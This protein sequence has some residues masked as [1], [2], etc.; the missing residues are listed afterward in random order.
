MTGRPDLLL[1]LD[2]EPW[3]SVNTPDEA[4]VIL[5][6]AEAIL[7][8]CEEAG[9]R[10]TL[11]VDILA[12]RRL[13]AVGRGAVAD[14]IA[15]QIRAAVAR[16]HDAQLHLH[17]HW[18]EAGWTG[19]AWRFPAD[20]YRLDAPGLDDAAIAAR[21]ESL[22]RA[23]IALLRE[24]AGDAARP[25]RAFRAGG[26]AIQ[27]RDGAVLRGLA[28]AG[29]VIDSSVVPG[30]RKRT[31]RQA[32]DFSAAP[33]L[34]TWRVGPEGG[35]LRPAGAGLLEVPVAAVDLGP[36]AGLAQWRYFRA[37]KGA[38]IGG[39]GHSRDAAGEGAG[40]GGRLARLARAADYGLRGWTPLIFPLPAPLLLG[41]ARAW[42]ARFG[43]QPGIAFSALLHPKGFT[44]CML[45]ELRGFL[46][47]IAPQVGF[48]TFG[49][50]AAKTFPQD[51]AP[52]Y[53]G[54]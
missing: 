37:P 44:T 24:A 25:V 45:D 7:A 54:A 47:G 12:L 35:V 8:A 4:A 53:A 46:A 51:G 6:P 28:A 1:S 49:Q 38:L 41:A 19:S 9:A 29:I 30:M 48:A 26:Y 3:F 5:P 36:R 42:L 52:C 13:R 16:G 22:A 39:A 23:G 20:S 33:T 31:G 43:S 10:A 40:Q 50:L 18:Q 11:F 21:T 17:P 15:G 2:Y 34:P 14:A 32:V 27:P